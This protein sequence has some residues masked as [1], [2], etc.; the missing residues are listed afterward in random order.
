VERVAKAKMGGRE[1]AQEEIMR[2]FQVDAGDADGLYPGRRRR[3]G[4]CVFR[5]RFVESFE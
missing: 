5:G 2:R 3:R 4:K 1:I